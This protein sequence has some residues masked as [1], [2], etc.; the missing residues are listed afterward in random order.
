MKNSIISLATISVL[1]FSGCSQKN[2]E[3]LDY[4]MSSGVDGGSSSSGYVNNVDTTT[5]VIDDTS[6][7][8]TSELIQ[9]LKSQLGTVYFDFDKFGI[10]PDMRNVVSNN[11][12]VL[13]NPKASSLTIKLEGNCD[14]FGTDEY[15]MALG[16]KRAQSVKQ[17]LV[18]QGVDA[19][20][21]STVSY[22]KNNPV[23]NQRSN[24]CWSK[25]RRVD[26]DL[27]P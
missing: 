25:N 9:G 11:A 13:K 15:N 24:S 12:R 3:I 17:A 18:S 20:H 6:T 26:F 23:C 22:G 2:P 10:R 1:I 16:L 19:S 27:L 8:T 4:S 5:G 14:E 21:I 7:G